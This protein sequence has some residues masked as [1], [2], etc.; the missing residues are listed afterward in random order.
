MKMENKETF[1]ACCRWLRRQAVLLL[2]L[3]SATFAAHATTPQRDNA[4]W[5]CPMIGTA[6]S[7]APTLWGNYGGTYPG[8]VS[9]WG[10]VQLTPETSTRP[11]ERG[12]YYAD[13]TIL[14]FTC[15]D[16][17]SGYP[18]GSSGSLDIIFM[19]G[20][21][22][23]VPSSYAGRAFSHSAE[24]AQPGYY[25]VR[26][27]DG[28]EVSATAATHAG[29]MRYTTSSDTTTV[30]VC[31]GGALSVK[32]A[33]EVRCEKSHAVLT[34]TRPMV[35]H[36]LR[37]D[38]L[39]AQFVTRQA[40]DVQLS[41]SA[42]G[43]N[44]S[45]ANGKAQLCGGDFQAVRL[46][47]Y[48]AWQSELQCVD[49]EGADDSLM[50]KFYTALYHAMLLPCNIADVGSQPQYSRFSPWD[51]FRTLHPLLALLKPEVQ[52][53]IVD[54]MMEE[55]ARNGA[56]SQGPM[57]G[58]HAIPI[59]L[60][61]YV[62]GVSRRSVA[63]LYAACRQ[64]CGKVLR[65]E[66]IRQYIHQGYVGASEAESVSLTSELAY[67]DW[68]MMRFAQLCG[69]SDG[70]ATY[71]KRA[72]NYANLWDAETL[73]MLPRDGNSYLR[74]SGELGYQESNRWTASLFA[75][76]NVQHLVNLCGGD[77]N[78][79]RRLQYAFA[80]G[81]VLFDN[82]TVFH[83]PWLYVWSRHPELAMQR[84]NSIATDCFADTPGG[85]PGN[86]DLGSMSSW[87]AFTVMGL[88]PVC[89]GT[90]EYIIVP[91]LAEAVT[92]HLSDGK[93]MRI[94]RGGASTPGFMPQP[95]LN[96][97]ALNRCHITHSELTAGGTLSYDWHTALDAATM[98]LP[99]SLSSGTPQFNVETDVKDG[100]R[101]RPDEAMRLPIRVSNS[102]TD[103]VCV[104]ALTC[105]GDTVASKNV[106]VGA[107]ESVA[108]TLVCRLYAEGQH[109]L[110]LA[111][112]S[113]SVCVVA[114]KKGSQRLRCTGI[115]VNPMVKLG[116]AVS[117]KFSVKNVGG[118]DCTQDVP[119]LFDGHSAVTIP[120]T[121][122]PG[123][124]C[125]YATTLHATDAVGMHT[126]SVLD[127]AEKLKIYADPLSATVLNM[128]FSNG[129]ATDISGFGNDGQCSGPLTWD[130]G[131]VTTAPKAF[132]E[133]PA[134]ASLMHPYQEFTMLTWVH[135]LHSDSKGYFDFLTKGDYNVL[136]IQGG[137]CLG[138]FA[139]GWGRGECEAVLPADWYDG[140]HLV[141]GVC[142]PGSIKIYIDG[143][144][145]QTVAVQGTVAASEM[146][147][148]L[149]RNAEMPYS[150]FGNMSFKATRIYAAA[151]SDEM[152]MQ[153]YRQS[154][155]SV[156]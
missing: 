41:V 14:K 83:Y 48:A 138:F 88:M 51:T 133:F 5:V 113:I 72:L 66:A 128:D 95:Q 20:A 47:A 80:S 131:A 55:Y 108:D 123:E 148:N 89:P 36:T 104:V 44:E 68:A 116:E 117:V 115:N 31:Q 96:G 87:F 64:S 106:F 18:N 69:D 10:M 145:R 33:K 71:A 129:S 6:I 152:I 81:N 40:L 103:G 7:D 132:V 24:E 150:R 76:H 109:T 8:A 39:Y 84:V 151:L 43:F 124:E 119:V 141:A 35:S 16:H 92:L 82:E 74:H 15:I 12:Y 77:S 57:T 134:S 46:A 97:E 147:W 114:Q 112:S 70:A 67:D 28:D 58:Y 142:S 29:I 23:A 30:V 37:G 118:K 78:F 27:D 102:G 19:R 1:Y 59:L 140:W 61:S 156:H 91:P 3:V 32:S 146:R 153:I 22:S 86:D 111:N 38:T 139:G 34:F 63:D 144:L 101:V 155:Q 98:Q 62:K 79:S 65:G 135:P 99:Y 60:D 121:L 9:P 90:D 125:E 120:M 49:L 154:P 126:V 42:T 53:D 93:T 73:F 130:D 75:P 105:E 2:M 149:G 110:H 4:K 137:N 26:F 56:L 52:A 54:N 21:H 17:N 50:H 11:S 25:R 136:K 45:L 143:Q 100:L 13:G 94:E 122:R 107:G 127:T 85:I